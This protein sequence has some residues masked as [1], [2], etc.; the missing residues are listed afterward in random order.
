MSL[1]ANNKT[2]TK[3]KHDILKKNRT[4]NYIFK[5]FNF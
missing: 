5:I 2:P 1:R 3:N 4:S